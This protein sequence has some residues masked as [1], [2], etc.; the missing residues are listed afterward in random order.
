MAIL[1]APAICFFAVKTGHRK[2]VWRQAGVALAAFALAFLP[3]IPGLQ[4]MFHSSGTHVYSEVPSLGVLIWTL[5]LE[6]LT[7]VGATTPFAMAAMWR[8]NMQGPIESWR[9]VLCLSVAL[10]PLLILFGV[11]VGTPLHIFVARYRLAAI[12]GIT[13]CWGLRRK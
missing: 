5:A 12:P 2:T 11:S 1:P 4:H 13:P 9:I 7:L 6:P 8:S 10:V 3:V